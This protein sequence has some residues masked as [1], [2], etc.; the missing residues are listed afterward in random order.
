MSAT[1]VGLSPHMVSAGEVEGEQGAHDGT[2]A[3][4]RAD[5]CVKLFVAASVVF[6]IHNVTHYGT[7]AAG[8]LVFEIGTILAATTASLRG[9]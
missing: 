2:R 5:S 8:P 1:A 3:C 4:D 7:A 6:V 9:F